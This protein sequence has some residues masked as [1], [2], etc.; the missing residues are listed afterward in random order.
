MCAARPGSTCPRIPR[1]P[2]SSSAPAPASPLSGASGSNGF[3]K[4]STKV[5]LHL[6]LLFLIPSSARELWAGDGGGPVSCPGCPS[7]GKGL[8]E[9]AAVPS[10]GAEISPN[11][12]KILLSNFASYLWQCYRAGVGFQRSFNVKYTFFTDHLDHLGKK[13]KFTF[14]PKPGTSI[15]AV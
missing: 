3:L 1:C 7:R 12:R 6:F 4:S 5:G 14:S 15:P 8:L 9:A 11:S 13:K 2:A 10:A